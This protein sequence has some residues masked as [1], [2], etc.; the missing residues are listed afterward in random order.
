MERIRFCGRGLLTAGIVVLL[1]CAADVGP[2]THSVSGTVTLN[3]APTEGIT[4]SFVPDGSGQ[5]AVGTTDA[6]GNY[7]LTTRKK[8][9]G[10]VAGRYKVTFAKYEGGPSEVAAAG[11]VHADYD[12]TNEY[13]EGYD[14]SAAAEIEPSKNLLPD[15]YA[16]PSTSGLTAEVVEGENKHD[17]NLE[18]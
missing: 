18:G 13:P 15:K 7:K 17:F 16:E 5:N 9:D 10:A 12:I 4:V 14:E 3:G 6:S 2:A 8:D 11:E 1:G